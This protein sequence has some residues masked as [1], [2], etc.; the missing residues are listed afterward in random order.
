METFPPLVPRLSADTLQ[1][2]YMLLC[3]LNPGLVTLCLQSTATV[4][5]S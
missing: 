1:V 2:Q 4:P 3:S 5:T